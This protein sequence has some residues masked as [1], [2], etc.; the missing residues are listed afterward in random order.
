MRVE[1]SYSECSYWT[2]GVYMYASIFTDARELMKKNI[3]EMGSSRSS[4]GGRGTP[5]IVHCAMAQA[6]K[7]KDKQRKP[8]QQSRTNRK[9]IK[10][11]KNQGK[12][13]IRKNISRALVCLFH[14]KK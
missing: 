13:K 7:T 11:R 10:E 5:R 6:T 3:R 9:T 1:I 4:G 14:E 8:N 2:F 12:A